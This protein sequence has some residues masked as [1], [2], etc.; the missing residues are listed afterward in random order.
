MKLALE[1][2]K[3]RL[4]KVNFVEASARYSHYVNAVE[5]AVKSSSGVALVMVLNTRSSFSAKSDITLCNASVTT[6]TVWL[7]ALIHKHILA[8][9]STNAPMHLCALLYH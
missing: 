3:A 2:G 7:T 9:H 8:S 5:L 6:S 1:E 4:E